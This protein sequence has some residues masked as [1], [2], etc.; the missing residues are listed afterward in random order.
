MAH[1]RQPLTSTEG[2]A[3]AN[4]IIKDQDL[5]D[6]LENFKKQ[7]SLGSI[8]SDLQTL[9][10]K[11]WANFLKRNAQK[12]QS[13]QNQ[14]FAK[15]QAE[16]SKY[17]YIARM[18]DHIYER[19]KEAKV[20]IN[21]EPT[22]RNRKGQIVDKSDQ[23]G[24]LVNLKIIKPSYVLFAGKTGCNTSQAKDKNCGGEKF[25]CKKGQTPLEKSCTGDHHFTMLPI[26]SAN[27]QP[28]ICVVIFQSQKKDQR[29]PTHWHSGLDVTVT[30]KRDHN[31]NIAV[32]EQNFGGRGKLY[33]NG[34]VCNFLGRK[35]QQE[36]MCQNQVALQQKY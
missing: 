17:S 14:K 3:L 22:Y 20:A 6:A 26:T 9:G 13:K 11:Y 30:P 31:G 27:G 33:P 24:E 36:H 15:D 2:L 23:Y 28:V 4:S 10:P 35:F 21:C 7:R 32:D 12:L 8:I 16:W 19:F 1:I 5:G 29:V 18:Y 25:L 34:P